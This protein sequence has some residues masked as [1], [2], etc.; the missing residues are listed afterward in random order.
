[1]INDFQI[2]L[3]AKLG[4]LKSDY[5]IEMRSFEERITKK[6][7]HIITENKQNFTNTNQKVE[8]TQ[9]EI[10]D[11][12][13]KAQQTIKEQNNNI[14]RK[15]NQEISKTNAKIEEIETSIEKRI[16]KEL[17]S[18]NNQMDGILEKMNSINDK[19]EKNQKITIVFL[20][21]MNIMILIMAVKT[22]IK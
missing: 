1:M 22:F 15:I 4:V 10:N 20:V 2:G 5:L 9:N 16:D 6:Y 14:I 19:V 3:D 18:L 13:I 11:N 8:K 7:E 17:N 21:L 12:I